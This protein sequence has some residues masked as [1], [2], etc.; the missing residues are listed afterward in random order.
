MGAIPRSPEIMLCR[1][2]SGLSR[3]VRCRRDQRRSDRLRR[4]SSSGSPGRSAL[5]RRSSVRPEARL[6]VR[7]ILSA[8]AVLWAVA[9]PLAVYAA[10]RADS[11]RPTASVFALAV[12]QLG[13]IVCHQRPERS[14]HLASFPM[15]VCARCTGIYA[16][17]A[18]ASVAT[19][20]WLR[21]SARQAAAARH[22]ASQ[23][24]NAA[25]SSAREARIV[26]LAAALPVFATLVYEWTT[27]DPPS[28]EL[29]ALT[30]LI[31]GAGV[32]W[33]LLRLE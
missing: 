27:G 14:F 25:A 22:Q 30:G 10:D 31:L 13:S 6:T 15:P 5:T 19:T 32:A 9:L 8:A 7:F 16:G 18:V 12:Y 28:N 2:R 11:A 26:L 3:G 1:F 4:T 21:V 33:I 29:R 24:T 17:A 20:L 23:E